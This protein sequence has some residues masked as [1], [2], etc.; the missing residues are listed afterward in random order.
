MWTQVGVAAAAAAQ[1]KL[2]Q[3]FHTENAN[4]YNS[5]LIGMVHERTAQEDDALNST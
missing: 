1:Q 3:T 4:V 5:S 2:L